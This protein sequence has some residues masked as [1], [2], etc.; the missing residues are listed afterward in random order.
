MG[1]ILLGHTIAALVQ[2][3]TAQSFLSQQSRVCLW[4]DS[5]FA[6]PLSLA[7]T[8]PSD[9]GEKSTPDSSTN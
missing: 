2:I 3:G 5:A 8:R 4:E 7:E 6:G 1:K 9:F